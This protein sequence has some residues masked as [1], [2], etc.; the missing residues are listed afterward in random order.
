MKK[1]I[2]NEKSP[3]FNK[4]MI[5]RFPFL[6][7]K[8]VWTGEEIKD[9][10]YSWTLFNEIPRGWRK[11]FGMDF[12]EELREACIETDFLDELM[13]LQI[14]EKFGT[15]RFYTNPIPRNIDHIIQKYEDLSAWI[16]IECGAPA[17]WISKDWICPWCDDCCKESRNTRPSAFDTI[18]TWYGEYEPIGD[19]KWDMILKTSNH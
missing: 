7:P 6:M 19:S 17:K 1:I 11:A 4:F 18:D 16:C 9:Y 14:K 3:E 12:M 10:D 8:N 13:I 15:L 2:F 5:E